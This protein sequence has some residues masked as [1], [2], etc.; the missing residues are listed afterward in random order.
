MSGALSGVQVVDVTNWIA[1]PFGTMLLGDLGAEVIK[2]ESPDG[3]G[4]RALGPP[5]QN[6][7]SH[8]FMGL[9]RNKRDIVVDLKTPEGQE[10]VRHL[11][12]RCDVLVQNM[13][14]GAAEGY[15]LGYEA[16][17]ALNPRLIYV[18]NTGYGTRGPL[19]DMPGFDLVM[20]GLGGVM[21]RGDAQPEFYHYFPPADMATGMLIAY[22]VCAA[23]YHRERTGTG[24]LIDTS[25]FA[26]ILA[27]QSGIFFFGDEPA[28]YMIHEV[29]P[30]IPTYRAFRDA[31]GQY[32]TLAALSE[33][34]WR[35][36]CKVA[37]L[38]ALGTDER[39]NS[40]LKRINNATELISLLQSK[41]S[42]HPRS[43]WITALNAEKIPSGPVY[44]PQDL[45]QEPH[46]Q[47]M[48]LLPSI[49]HP[50]AGEIHM[51]GLPVEF[52][53]SP[54]SIRLPP[55]THGQHTTEVLRD[56]GYGDEKM[57]ALLRAGAVRQQQPREE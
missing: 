10:V 6:G 51:V 56:L 5:F 7:E 27:L 52:H 36:L 4:C 11:A 42:E 41:F 13:R 12:Q 24:Q 19:K 34:Q 54:A 14:P 38:D 33:D 49:Q 16:L 48:H 39:F 23:L 20:Q 46:V 43:H 55:P 29:A 2:V 57:Q 9:N 35:R 44:S 25:L 15:G 45:R 37:G 22:A 8:F 21:Y 17:R 47:E 30:Y 26:T 28:P 31:A 18:T 32:F 50:V 1:G 40:L 3:D 53:G